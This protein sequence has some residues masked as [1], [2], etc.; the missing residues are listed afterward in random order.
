METIAFIKGEKMFKTKRF[1]KHL[2]GVLFL[3]LGVILF[4]YYKPLSKDAL[5]LL[6]DTNMKITLLVFIVV[7]LPFVKAF[8]SKLHRIII[9]VFNLVEKM[10]FTD[11]LKI[12]FY[13]M[14]LHR[15]RFIRR[16][17]ILWECCKPTLILIPVWLFFIIIFHFLTKKD[18]LVLLDE[19]KFS[20]FS[21]V[22]LV[23]VITI[24]D[25]VTNYKSN[26]QKQFELYIELMHSLEKMMWKV[27]KYNFP[28][29]EDGYWCINWCYTNERFNK[30]HKYIVSDEKSISIKFIKEEIEELKNILESIK[31]FAVAKKIDTNENNLIMFI[32]DCSKK[33]NL[34]NNLEQCDKKEI[35]ELFSSIYWRVLKPIRFPWRRDTDLDVK[36]YTIL[37]NRLN[38]KKDDDIYMDH[39]KRLLVDDNYEASYP[40]PI[41]KIKI[42]KHKSN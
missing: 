21:S 14:K 18:Y 3:I 28:Y 1:L 15:R 17:K 20:F 29:Y 12:M 5:A 8:F 4:V 31:R 25:K 26:I 38:A 6:N 13:K 36:I 24:R 9:K 30:I 27:V 33:I 32:D 19:A 16:F 41:R 22:I 35:D 34:L 42:K 39:Y 2:C 11:D 23:C 37:L 10:L 7:S 40:K